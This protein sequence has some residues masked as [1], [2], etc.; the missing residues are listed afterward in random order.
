MNDCSVSE[1]QEKP[2]SLSHNLNLELFD[3][4]KN[5]KYNELKDFIE[6]NNPNK[7]EIDIAI[8]QCLYKFKSENNDYCETMKLLFKYAD[9]NFCN[10]TFDGNN[11]LMN[12]CAKCNLYLFDLIFGQNTSIN[13]DNNKNKFNKQNN[14]NSIK[15]NITYEDI[16]IYQVDKKNQN[17]FHYLF[18]EMYNPN[19]VIEPI[20]RK[21]IK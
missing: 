6:K 17:I 10:P 19:G 21:P 3:L 8:R 16:N 11:L 1:E 9:L 20:K 13:S 18:T 12:I 5:A 2:F 14:K 15:E 4:S 7:I